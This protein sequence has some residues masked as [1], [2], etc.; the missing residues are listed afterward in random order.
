[1]VD[2]L[3]ELETTGWACLKSFLTE[4]DLI[5]LEASYSFCNRYQQMTEEQ[6]FTH[7]VPLPNT[8]M[9]KMLNQ[10][11]NPHKMKGHASTSVLAEKIRI[12]LTSIL[13][14]KPVL[15]QDVIM[16][17]N[18]NHQTLH[19]H[20]DFSYW[21]VSKPE[22]VILWCPLQDCDPSNGVVGFSSGSHLIGIG[23]AIDLTTG[24]PQNL[25]CETTTPT[26]I[27][28]YPSMKR[29]D[30]IIFTPLLW[31][32]SGENSSSEERVAWSSSWLHPENTW[33]LNRAPNHPLSRKLIDGTIV[34]EVP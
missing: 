9:Q 14:Y 12:R 5:H 3:N 16:S 7:D 28:S 34:T 13:N 19:W 26:L 6:L 32:K 30:A 17:K 29:G 21:P 4:E 8:S 22:G 20:Q 31:H 15:F 33:D 25:T 11:L 1:M 23:P 27:A 18:Q 24:N 10:W 2:I